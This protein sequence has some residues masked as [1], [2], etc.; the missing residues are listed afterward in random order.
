M[1]NLL[2]LVFLSAAHGHGLADASGW[3]RLTSAGSDFDYQVDGKTFEGYVALPTN[4][5]ATPAP[6][7]VLIA[8]QWMGLIDYE[9][10]RADQMAAMGYV[11]FAVDL[12]GKGV[13]CKDKTCAAAAM[14]TAMANVTKLRRL[15]AAGTHQLLDRGVNSS[16][17][18][19][20]GYCFGGA[21]VLEL[22]RHPGVGASLDVT[23]LAVA[24]MHG[25]LKPYGQQ[26]TPGELSTHVQVHHA[27]LDFAGDNGLLALEGELAAAATGTAA[28]WETLKYGKCEHGWTAPGTPVYQP[29]E[30]LRAH[31]SAFNFFEQARRGFAVAEPFAPLAWCREPPAFSMLRAAPTPTMSTGASASLGAAALALVVM[32][33]YALGRRDANDTETRRALHDEM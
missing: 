9:K 11:A 2:K 19:A 14:Q 17:L 28:H 27:A 24:P 23:Y 7:G 33:A 26:S 4:P 31:Q 6:P 1:H 29:A 16:A 8:H 22:A 18:T 15:I 25:V 10:A 32:A 5:I 13:R 3:R 20:I 12:Y 30:A 21:A